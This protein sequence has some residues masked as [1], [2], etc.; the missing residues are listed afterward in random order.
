MILNI[1]Y[2]EA[3]DLL[4]SLYRELPEGKQREYAERVDLISSNL[5]H[6][7]PDG[8]VILAESVSYETNLLP[9]SH[10]H[11]HYDSRALADLI[12][13]LA[14]KLTGE[15]PHIKWIMDHS[16]NCLL[17]VPSTKNITWTKPEAE[18]NAFVVLQEV[19]PKPS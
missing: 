6:P 9:I 7:H 3:A 11:L 12:A 18:D 15:A 1:Q 10:E 2:P 16:R 13:A 8:K 5:R 19:T 17:I 4:W 14:E